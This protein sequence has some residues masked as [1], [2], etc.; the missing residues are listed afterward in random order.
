MVIHLIQK[1]K[2]VPIYI[3]EIA[4]KDLRGGLATLNQVD[5]SE[6]NVEKHV[7]Y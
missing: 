5:N 2:Q 4:P 3:A 1:D 6:A 7:Q